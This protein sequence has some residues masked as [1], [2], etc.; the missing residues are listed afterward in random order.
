MKIHLLADLHLEFAPVVI[1]DADVIVLAGDID[2]GVRGIEWA[3]YHFTDRPVIYVLGNHEFY[4]HDILELKQTI[5]RMAEGTNVR[6]LE[7]TAV[8]IAK[9]R[10]SAFWVAPCGLI[11][12]CVG[13]P[14]TPWPT[15]NG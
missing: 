8:E 9:S 6:V 3:L 5:N 4:R 7:N 11:S 13:I 10:A 1:P 12:P 2:I 15:P 14:N